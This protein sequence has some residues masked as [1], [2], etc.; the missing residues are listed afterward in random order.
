MN[1]NAAMPETRAQNT[2]LLIPIVLLSIL[3]GTAVIRGPSIVSLSGFGSA[4]IVAA[5]LCW[6]PML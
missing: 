2:Y 3:A 6:R 4:I 1:S 5:P